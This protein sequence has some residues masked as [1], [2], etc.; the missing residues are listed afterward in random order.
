LERF[1]DFAVDDRILNGDKMKLGEILNKEITIVGYKIRKSKYAKPNTELYLSLQFDLAG[2]R[3]VAFTGSNVLIN[4]IEKYADKM[5]FITT[6]L[7]IDK[8]F[9]F[10]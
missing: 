1:Q 9:T 7:K 10:S 6:I 5:P 8:Y 4:Q 3:H 2:I